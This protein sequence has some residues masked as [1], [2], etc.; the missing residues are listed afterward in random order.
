MYSH[1]QKLKS[2]KAIEL[3]NYLLNVKKGKDEGIPLEE[4]KNLYGPKPPISK[5]V[6]IPRVYTNR[7]YYQ[8]KGPHKHVV[9]C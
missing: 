9:Y 2:R 3:K 1:D 8:W 6:W 7:F 4:L 5:H